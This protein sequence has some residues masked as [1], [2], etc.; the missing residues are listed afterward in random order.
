MLYFPEEDEFEGLRLPDGRCYVFADGVLRDADG[1][2]IPWR[3][4]PGPHAHDT[5]RVAT[6]T[7]KRK[8][9]HMATS[10]ISVR[11]TG[12][13]RSRPSRYGVDNWDGFASHGSESDARREVR[14]SPLHAWHLCALSRFAFTAL[15]NAPGEGGDAGLVLYYHGD[16]RDRHGF[17]KARRATADAMQRT[18]LLGPHTYFSTRRL[19][20]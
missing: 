8:R 1:E 9:R 4:R 17:T 14:K 13:V 16:A 15:N 3:A 7:R 5:T 19:S 10:R 6:R 18:R 12:V 11:S 20:K 2:V